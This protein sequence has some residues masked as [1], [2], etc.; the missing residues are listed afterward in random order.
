MFNEKLKTNEQVKGKKELF[1]DIESHC[2]FYRMSKR[3]K[4]RQRETYPES[5]AV[6]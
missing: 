2:S 5:I 4:I 1:G 3:A 6:L